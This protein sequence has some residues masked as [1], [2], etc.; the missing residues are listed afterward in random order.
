MREPPWWSWELE[1][2]SHL[3]RRMEDRGFTELD[4]RAM[5]FRAVAIREDV[6]EGRFVV[7]TRLRGNTWEVV[8]EPDA[9]DELIVVITAYR[10]GR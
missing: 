5:L 3:E 6:L 1:L 9:N 8:V 10:V 4:L 2:T 7:V